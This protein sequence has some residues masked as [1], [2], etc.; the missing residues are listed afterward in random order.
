M[1]KT[2]KVE[3]TVNK[4][5]YAVKYATLESLSQPLQGKLA[6]LALKAMVV[7]QILAKRV[8][9]AA[10]AIA[11][12]KAI[13]ETSEEFGRENGVTGAKI[14]QWIQA[15]I[16]KNGWFE[17]LDL[18]QVISLGEI[19]AQIEEMGKKGEEEEPAAK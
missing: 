16:A 18:N 4:V 13:R 7:R 15:Q 10:T 9:G 14:E 12:A 1:A 3:M 8:Y 19:Q 17:S 11:G 2:E 5:K 6:E